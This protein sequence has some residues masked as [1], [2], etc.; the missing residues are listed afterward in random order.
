[1][2]FILDKLGEKLVVN[3]QL[4]I[5]LVKKIST[6][7]LEEECLYNNRQFLGNRLAA[8][9]QTLDLSTQVQILVPQF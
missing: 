5:L 7:T 1:M 9:H 6:L 2:L 4:D 3:L 8:G